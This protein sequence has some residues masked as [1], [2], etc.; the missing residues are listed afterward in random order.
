M[1][2]GTYSPP[3]IQRGNQRTHIRH[4]SFYKAVVLDHCSTDGRW[5][6]Y[7]PSR[8]FFTLVFRRFVYILFHF[9]LPRIYSI[10]MTSSCSSRTHKKCNSGVVYTCIG[11]VYIIR[12]L[13]NRKPG[14][15][16]PN[17]LPL[18]LHIYHTRRP[19]V[20]K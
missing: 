16:N 3:L 19:D 7:A 10:L 20:H 9:D 18:P 15:T 17:P 2:T 1:Y 14:E 13:N 12:R 4:R 11:N 8:D 6:V 5:H